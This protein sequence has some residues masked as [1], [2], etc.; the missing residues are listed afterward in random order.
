[1]NS[2]DRFEDRKAQEEPV[3][4]PLRSVDFAINFRFAVRPEDELKAQMAL[5]Y[6]MS[7]LGRQVGDL[8][9]EDLANRNLP[10]IEF[11][12]WQPGYE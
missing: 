1:M 9:R 6:A 12:S 3:G 7:R 2:I 11:Q 4:P 10:G 8:I 5:E